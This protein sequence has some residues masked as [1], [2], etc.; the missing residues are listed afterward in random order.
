M[1][2]IPMKYTAATKKA[3]IAAAGCGP[4]STF[5]SVADVATITG[6]W[7]TYLYTVARGEH[8]EMNKETAV[9]ICKSVLLGAAGYYAGYK[10]ATR[11]FSLIP[12]AGTLLG[13]GISA[14]TNILFTYRFA[15][16]ACTVFS[17]NRPGTKAGQWA[18]EI[19]SAFRGNGTLRDVMEI[20]VLWA[21]G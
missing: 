7:G 5:S 21:N 16:T 12:G 3:L 11:L 8:V 15:L 2:T 10:M 1:N 13:M 9:Q 18:V 6:I 19:I 20:A 17:A 4:L 14:L